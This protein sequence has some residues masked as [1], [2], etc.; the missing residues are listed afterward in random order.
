ML[1]G[2]TGQGRVG[3]FDM[4]D[5]RGTARSLMEQHVVTLEELWLRYWANGGGADEQELDAYVNGA[6]VPEPFDVVII[7]WA[8]EDL[9][10]G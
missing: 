3:V 7:G 6:L 1:A 8:L 9:V 5:P 4:E 10:G 2:R